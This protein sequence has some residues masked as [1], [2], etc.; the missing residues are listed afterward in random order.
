MD[1]LSLNGVPLQEI[2]VN[3]CQELLYTNSRAIMERTTHHSKIFLSYKSSTQD[4]GPTFLHSFR[5]ATEKI[6]TAKP[7]GFRYSTLLLSKIQNT[8]MAEFGKL[9]MAQTH[10][11]SGNG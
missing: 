1:A 9:V 11:V 7:I 6:T 3:A 4:T 2:H 10:A 5:A 8:Q